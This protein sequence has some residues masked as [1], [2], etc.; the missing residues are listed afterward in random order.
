MS[1]SAAQPARI[2]QANEARSA[3]IE[4]LRALAALGVLVGHVFGVSVSFGAGTFGHRLG[5]AG[6]YG[7]FLFF[8]LTGYLLFWPFAKRDFGAGGDI[9]LGTYA[10]NRALRILP[11]YY[12]V[13]VV[14]LF[15]NEGGGTL[16]QWWRFGTFTQSFFSDTVATVDGPM[17]SLAVEV[18]FYLLLP[19]IAWIVA[20]VSG[21]SARRAA[22]LLLALGACGLALWWVKVHSAGT[23]ADLRWR[24]SLPA[25]FLSFIPGM[26]LALARARLDTSPV[27]A[28][29]P[30]RTALLLA[31]IP[32]WLLA[33][34]Q[35]G[36]ALPL[37]AVAS[38]LVLAAVVLPG[39]NSAILRSL[40]WRPL[41][42]LGVAS[43]SLYLWHLP[44]VDSLGRRSG[45]GF[46]GLLA[47]AVPSC[48]AVA[49]LSYLLVER[50]FLSLRRR[51]GP[52]AAAPAEYPAD[53]PEAGALGTGN[54]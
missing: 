49:A 28:R 34:D 31:S 22:L 8:A 30:P 1:S 51:W 46:P 5:L 35:I 38:A 17:W 47:L 2:V 41:A 43:Y 45:A 21:G 10:R 24:Y 27:R 44:M 52:T 50:P 48:I 25:C 33:V 14:L 40:E 13:V 54:P 26:L 36:W 11:L 15:V 37:C 39:G 3:R 42:A 7:V 29:L 18:Q 23:A 9:R 32:F 4:A 53:A 6:G 20:Q 19:L 16:T 12:F